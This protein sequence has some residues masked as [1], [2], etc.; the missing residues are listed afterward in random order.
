MSET[1][2]TE[3]EDLG[4]RDVLT[5]LMRAGARKLLAQALDAKVAALLATYTDQQDEQGRA[6]VVRNGQQAAR[7]IQTGIGPVTV[8]VPK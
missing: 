6:V 4:G 8:Q 7:E 3:Q 2:K 1:I 5:E